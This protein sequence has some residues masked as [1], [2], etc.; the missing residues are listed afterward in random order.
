MD[1][2]V[3][4]LPDCETRNEKSR[5]LSAII[6]LVLYILGERLKFSL[7]CIIEIGFRKNL[8]WIWQSH[9]PVIE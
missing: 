9:Y 5:R 6:K 1:I 4:Y 3:I 7:F 8:E 2:E